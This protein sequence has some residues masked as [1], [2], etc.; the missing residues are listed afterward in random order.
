MTPQAP[1]P[2]SYRSSKTYDYE[3][4][5]KSRLLGDRLSV[6][7]SA[8]DIDWRNIQLSTSIGG[9]SVVSNGG[10]ARSDG[11]EWELDYALARGVTINLNGAYTKAYLTQATPASV[12]GRVGDRLP[13][14]PL[15]QTSAG[16][17]YEHPLGDE[18]SWFSGL[19][20]R[21]SDDRYGDFSNSGP[22]QEMPSVN[23]F[24]VRAGLES[25]RW[26]LKAYVKNLGNRLA[27]E[28]TFSETLAGNSGVLNA[29]VFTPRTIGLELTVRFR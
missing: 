1:V 7:V 2:H 20:W 21:F 25:S 15:W 27:V 8:F 6:D 14:V 4:G 3:I 19:S 23:I 17:E 28:D 26:S 16:V 9:Y 22:R 13:L 29:T 12:N 24:D 10:T 5:L 11:A 18:Y